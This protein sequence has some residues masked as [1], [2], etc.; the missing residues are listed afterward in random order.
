MYHS[1]SSRLGQGGY[2]KD[3]LIRYGMFYSN[4]PFDC[5]RN[6]CWGTGGEQR[7]SHLVVLSFVL[8]SNAAKSSAA[9]RK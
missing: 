1:S 7:V 4:G 2:S 8:K 3:G 5:C 9:G 6:R